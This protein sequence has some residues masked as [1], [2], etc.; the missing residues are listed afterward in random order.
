MKFTTV[1]GVVV[2][3]CMSAALGVVQAGGFQ[4]AE[5]SISPGGGAIASADGCRRMQATL[6]EPVNGRLTGGD[7]V[8][9]AG[10]QARVGAY[11]RDSIFNDGFQECQ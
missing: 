8:V 1:S 11:P 5:H 3:L 6:G 9:V 7:F 4:L 2:L 10:F